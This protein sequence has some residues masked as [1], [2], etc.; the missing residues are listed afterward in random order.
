MSDVAE[1]LKALREEVAALRKEVSALKDRVIPNVNIAA[2]AMYH[3]GP[4]PAL[5]MPPYQ[6]QPNLCGVAEA[7]YGPDN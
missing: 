2:P 6:F 3:N 4:V 1:E 5:P 7:T